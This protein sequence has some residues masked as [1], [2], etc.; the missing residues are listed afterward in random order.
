MNQPTRE[1]VDAWLDEPITQL[2]LK[3]LQQR[4]EFLQSHLASGGMYVAGSPNTTAENTV[5]CLARM[6]EVQELHDGIRYMILPE[7]EDED[8]SDGDNSSGSSAAGTA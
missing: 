5:W 6:K 8:E 3:R 1:E 7:K 4:H 2:F